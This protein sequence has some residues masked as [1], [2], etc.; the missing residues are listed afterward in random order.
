[1]LATQSSLTLAGELG[2]RPPAKQVPL[3][4]LAAL[5]TAPTDDP[6]L[7]SRY[8]FSVDGSGFSRR[9]DPLREIDGPPND[10]RRP[11][12]VREFSRYI[13][14]DENRMRNPKQVGVGIYYEAHLNAEQIYKL[15]NCAGRSPKV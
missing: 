4:F 7:S 1:V 15:I 2:L 10:P 8:R 5:V 6:S 12:P 13:A 14:L 9:S 11:A 3:S